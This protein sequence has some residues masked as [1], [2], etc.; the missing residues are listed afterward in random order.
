MRRSLLVFGR[1]RHRAVL[2]EA[3]LA[4]E[5]L[6]CRLQLQ[7]SDLSADPNRSL[8]PPSGFE[9]SVTMD[10]P[11]IHFLPTPPAGIKFEDD[12]YIATSEPHGTI[13]CTVSRKDVHTPVA[14]L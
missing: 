5:C 10:A 3:A 13:Q 9:Q 4:L 8:T 7:G 12:V 6:S 1:S 14:R 11:N 2:H